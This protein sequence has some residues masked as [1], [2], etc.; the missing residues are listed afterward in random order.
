MAGFWRVVA[1]SLFWVVWTE[2]C[3]PDRPANLDCKSKEDLSVP[4]CWQDDNNEMFFL[5]CCLL[6]TPTSRPVFHIPIIWNLVFSLQMVLVLTPK[7]ATTWFCGTPAWSCLIVWALFR[8]VKCGMPIP[9]ATPTDHCSRAHVHRCWQSGA[10]QAVSGNQ[11][12]I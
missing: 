2:S 4:K 11:Y 10:N 9:G 3:Q 7:N 8:S 1:C 12:F 6:G 5:G